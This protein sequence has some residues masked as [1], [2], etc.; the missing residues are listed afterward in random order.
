MLFLE[1]EREREK[2]MHFTNGYLHNGTYDK[3][4][5]NLNRE[6]YNLVWNVQSWK[7][8]KKHAEPIK[9]YLQLVNATSMFLGN[10]R[11]KFKLGI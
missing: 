7:K 10:K 5:R 4:K 6:F 11:K 3:S 1:R 2:W 8:P 9:E